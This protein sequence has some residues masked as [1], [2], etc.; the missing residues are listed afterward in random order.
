MSSTTVRQEPAPLLSPRQWLRLIVVYLLIPL[1]LFVCALDLGWWPAWAFTL[2]ILAAGLGGRML[3]ERR[4][5]GLLAERQNLEKAL[6][7]K[8]WDKVLEPGM[9]LR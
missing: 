8:P 3:A 4:H 2:L 5:P 9:P 7:A 1:I 6:D